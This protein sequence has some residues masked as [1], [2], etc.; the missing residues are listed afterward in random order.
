MFRRPVFWAGFT[1]VTLACAIF[2][3][4]NVPRAFSIVELDLQMDRVAALAEAREL[5]EQFGWGP[6]GYRQAASFRVDDQVRSFVELEAGGA[7]TFADLMRDGPY[8]P[9]QWIVRHF[10][11][12]EVREVL[13]RFPAGRNSLWLSRTAVRRR[14][15]S[16]LGRRGCPSYSRKQRRRPVERIA[17]HL[18]PGGVFSARAAGRAHRSHICL[19]TQRDATRRRP[20]PLTY[21]RQR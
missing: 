13:L 18:R 17:R 4:L 11:G 5:S 14:T 7:E 8:Y 6:S 12:G 2:A 16:H 15:R 20:I 3:I 9:Y 10:R 21:C 1:T 19:R